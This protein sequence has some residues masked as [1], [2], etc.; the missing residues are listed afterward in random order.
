MDTQSPLFRKEVLENRTD[1]LHGEVTIAVPI[2]WQFVGFTL[3]GMLTVA[4]GFLFTATYS[5]VET[6]TGSIASEKGTAV[7]MPTRSG[8]V[9][10]V[11]VVDGEA[12]S[13]GTPLAR[14]RSEEDLTSG[15]TAPRRIMESLDEQDRRLG[16]QSLYAMRAASADRSRL[17]AL[18]AGFE[19]E[20]VS[21][22]AQKAVQS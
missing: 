21:L 15:G 13:A 12:V 4:I 17:L 3:L 7:I 18:V 5:R 10:S 11:L 19:D 6:V 2:S 1:R 20:I 9:A 8:I 16:I 14:I 22:T